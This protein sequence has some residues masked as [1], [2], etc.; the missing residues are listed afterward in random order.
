MTSEEK[1]AY[2]RETQRLINRIAWWA[3]VKMMVLLLVWA[4]AV[5]LIARVLLGCG[6]AFRAVDDIVIANDSAPPSEVGNVPMLET[7]EAATPSEPDAS[8]NAPTEAAATFDA[9][10]PDTSAEVSDPL[11]AGADLSVAEDAPDVPVLPDAALCFSEHGSACP[12][13]T[14]VVYVPDAQPAPEGAACYPSTTE[15]PTSELGQPWLCC[16]GRCTYH[17]SANADGGGRLCCECFISGVTCAFATDCCAGLS[18]VGGMC[19]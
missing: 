19:Q 6:P 2:D 5:L 13:G 4:S 16:L 3:T 18:C 12:P 15:C 11:D 14:R 17:C 9:S 7:P 8:L 1:L 10:T